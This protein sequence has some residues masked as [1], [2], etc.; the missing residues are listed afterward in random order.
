MNSTS[1]NTRWATDRCTSSGSAFQRSGEALL[2]A[3]SI[4]R[5][6]A[7]SSLTSLTVTPPDFATTFPDRPEGEPF[8]RLEPFEL[9]EPF[10]RFEP[11]EPLDPL[12]R[13]NPLVTIH[14]LRTHTAATDR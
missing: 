1:V 9:V 6:R 7:S 13:F 14:H 8:E 2:A 11:V 10:E 4:S 5:R 3:R 12:D